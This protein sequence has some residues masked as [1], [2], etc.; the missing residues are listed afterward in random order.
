MQPI[1][2]TQI[3]TA[4][5]VLQKLGERINEHA[6]RSVRQIPL[7]NVAGQLAGQIGVNAMEQTKQVEAI[8]GQL[9]TWHSELEQRRRQNVFH[10][11]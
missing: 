5:E 3:R 6:A 4:I 2:P 11:V 1:T 9:Q 8:T 7:S 10:R